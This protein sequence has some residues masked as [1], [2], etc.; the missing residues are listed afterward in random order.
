MVRALCGHI[1]P[2][3]TGADVSLSTRVPLPELL[4]DKLLRNPSDGFRGP[5]MP[6]PA[7]AWRIGLAALDAE[8]IAR[9]DTSYAALRDE[10]QLELLRRME[11]G[12]LSDPAWSGMPPDSFFRQR[13]LHDI[14]GLYY[15]HPHAWSRIGFGGPA[16]PRGYVRMYFDR[17]DPWEPREARAD[18]SDEPQTRR[19]NQRVR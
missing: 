4:D 6:R 18:G 7:H 17:R 1:V 3:D 14:C 15:A 2:Q 12:K 10:L 11:S 13:V 16:N 9:H 19:E 5:G 8:S